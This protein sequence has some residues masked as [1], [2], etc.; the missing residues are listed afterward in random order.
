MSRVAIATCAGVDVDP[1]APLL[2]GA[3]RAHGVEA[4]QRVWDDPAVEW[5]GYDLVVVR[6]T[7]D[8]SARRDEFLDWARE[9]PRLANPYE[10]LVY[11]SD[12]HYLADLAARGVE[13]VP[14]HF[15]DVGAPST[16][17]WAEVTGPARGD[18]VVKP[19]VG[20]GSM[21]AERFTE[22]DAASAFAHVADL[23]A[24][25]RDVL[26]QP[27][28]SSV[29]TE[30]ERAMVF[31]D[32]A[33]SHAMH[34]AALLNVTELDRNFLYRRRQM[35]LA[36]LDPE[37]LAVAVRVLAS[38]G[39]SDLLYARVD[40]VRHEGLW[41]VLELELVEPSLFLTHYE[42]AAGVLAAAIAR[43]VAVSA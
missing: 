12:K 37:T 35:S 9:V 28:V 25:G 14:S 34:K 2:L 27:Y 32:G 24:R 3:L 6:S 40:L 10:V 4:E 29:D 23:H 36:P 16:F 26:V 1:D 41:R 20:A 15:L 43:R 33:F 7:W 39:A 13:V 8:Y 17:D 22:A 21:H 5:H 30:G 18:V 11:S 19:A 42:S 38:A 31:I